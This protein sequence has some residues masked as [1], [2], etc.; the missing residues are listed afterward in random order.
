MEFAPNVESGVG[1]KFH[2][3]LRSP[4]PLYCHRAHREVVS[5]SEI[6]CPPIYCHRAHMPPTTLPQPLYQLGATGGGSVG[7]AIEPCFLCEAPVD[8]K[9]KPCGHVVMCAECAQRAKKC[10]ICKPPSR[11][12]VSIC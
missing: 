8:V 2:G 1:V 11:P 12:P 4:A 6:T 7:V 3:S 10:P 5:Q 9:F